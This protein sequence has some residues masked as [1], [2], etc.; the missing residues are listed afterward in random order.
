MLTIDLRMIC[1][2]LIGIAVLLSPTGDARAQK[3][4][5]ASRTSAKKGDSEVIGMLKS[6]HKYLKANDLK[7]KTKFVRRDAVLGESDHGSTDFAIRQ[8]NLFRISV[9]NGGKTDLFVSDGVSLWIYRNRR[10]QFVQFDAKDTALGTMYSAAGL[11]F[12]PS[13]ILDA[14]W[15]VDYLEGVN[16][17]VRVKTISAATVSGRRCRGIRVTRF[18]D[19]FDFWIDEVAPHK[20]C[21]LVSRRS[22]GSSQSVTTHTFDWTAAA[23]LEA[24]TFRFVPPKGAKQTDSFDPL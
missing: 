18:E 23:S 2:A 12:M 8:P 7:F 1:A 13:R 14:F 6:M 11:M 24:N 3:D 9:T 4:G 21:K 16:E 15:T 20:P 17:D 10:Q 22:D 5:Q 19:V